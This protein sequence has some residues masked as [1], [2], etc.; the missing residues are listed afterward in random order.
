MRRMRK[1]TATALLTLCALMVTDGAAIAAEPLAKATESQPADKAVEVVKQPL[2]DLNILQRDVAPV[3]QRA[4]ASP[5]A[6]VSNDNCQ[7][8]DVEIQAL[9]AALGP[10][11]DLPCSKGT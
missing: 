10:D 2:N 7:A 3:L 11:I 6:H 5:Y 9:N 4:K 1:T 8:L